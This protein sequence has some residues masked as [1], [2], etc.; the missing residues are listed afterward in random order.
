MHGMHHQSWEPGS[1]TSSELWQKS[2][3]K[4]KKKQLQVHLFAKRW[5][6]WSTTRTSF[7]QRQKSWRMCHTRCH[8]SRHC[9]CS[10]RSSTVLMEFAHQLQ[11]SM[12]MPGLCAIS[13]EFW[14]GWLTNRNLL[15]TLVSWK[16][17]FVFFFFNP[18]MPISDRTGGILTYCRMQCCWSCW[19]NL[20][21]ALICP[22][23]SPRT[24]FFVFFQVSAAISEAIS[25]V[26]FYIFLQPFP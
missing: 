13:S 5:P 16:V 22:I 3:V 20:A 23:G 17:V 26:I 19:S 9:A 1:A 12:M 2:Q 18:F 10:L 4:T 24:D 25:A 7:C 15:R 14:K 6:T 11:L 8:A 21:L